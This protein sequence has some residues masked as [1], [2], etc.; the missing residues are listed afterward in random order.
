MVVVGSKVVL[1]YNLKAAL[2]KCTRIARLHTET[3]SRHKQKNYV[4]ITIFQRIQCYVTGFAN[5]SV[6]K[7]RQS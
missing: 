6:D 5:T 7:G 1:C 2:L 4:H 3:I